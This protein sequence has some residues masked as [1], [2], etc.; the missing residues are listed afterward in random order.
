MIIGGGISI[1]V[2]DEFL[3]SGFEYM[4]ILRFCLPRGVSVSGTMCLIIAFRYLF[5]GEFQS[6]TLSK[7][8]LGDRR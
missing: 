4:F 1:L 5:W 7:C 8:F 3:V 6:R 2:T